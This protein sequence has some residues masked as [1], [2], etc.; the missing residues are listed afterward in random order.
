M[1]DSARRA[2]GGQQIIW[3][4]EREIKNRG[5]AYWWNWCIQGQSKSLLLELNYSCDTFVDEWLQKIFFN[6]LQNHCLSNDIFLREALFVGIQTANL[7]TSRVSH[8]YTSQWRVQVAI[9][10]PCECLSEICL[11]CA[12]DS[13]MQTSVP[14]CFKWGA[15]L[16]AA[17]CLIS[18]TL[19][20]Y[21]DCKAINRVEI[22]ISL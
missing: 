8:E 20:C 3:L 15:Q 1:W 10:H 7:T 17:N 6:N 12:S 16:F 19:S 14:C 21:W 18:C 11:N 9:L 13:F 2:K 4:V 22:K 5:R